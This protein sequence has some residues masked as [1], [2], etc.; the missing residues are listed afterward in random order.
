M[1]LGQVI[2]VWTLSNN[3]PATVIHYVIKVC[4]SDFRSPILFVVELGM[5]MYSNCAHVRCAL[6]ERGCIV[7][8]RCLYSRTLDCSDVG[9][10]SYNEFKM[11]ELCVSCQSIQFKQ[12]KL[13]IVPK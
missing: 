6:Y 7:I 1:H 3:I 12:T 2:E 10:L 8:N 5:Q 13:R 11:H 4:D 9:N